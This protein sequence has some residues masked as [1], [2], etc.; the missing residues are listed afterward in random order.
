MIAPIVLFPRCETE[1][2]RNRGSRPEISSNFPPLPTIFRRNPGHRVRN[3]SISPT[4]SEIKEKKLLDEIGYAN[5]R[6][7]KLFLCTALIMFVYG[8]FLPDDWSWSFGAL[9]LPI[10]WAVNNIPS[11]N[12]L[13][14]ASSIP[15][16]VQGFFGF[17]FWVSVFS[18]ILMSARDPLG[19]RVFFGFSRPGTSFLKAFLF[20]YFLAFPVLLIALWVAVCLPIDIAPENNKAWG[21]RLIIHMLQGRFLMS[22]IGGMVTAS[23]ALLIWLLV[24][25]VV[26]PFALIKSRR[27]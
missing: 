18:A 5:S 4:P 9:S 13:S 17:S 2:R 8:I 24:V 15:K 1:S 16:L 6:L 25:I 26:G 3:N 23:V 21:A 27:I 11:I 10:S 20:V 19:D 22:T 14:A 12:A 7:V